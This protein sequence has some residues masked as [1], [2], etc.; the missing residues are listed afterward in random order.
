[1]RFSLCPVCCASSKLVPPQAASTLFGATRRAAV[2]GLPA[3][4]AICYATRQ[5]FRRCAADMMSGCQPHVLPMHCVPS[6]YRPFRCPPALPRAPAS[7]SWPALPRPVSRHRAALGCCPASAAASLRQR[8]RCCRTARL[9]RRSARHAT[10]VACALTSST[11][12]EVRAD[13]AAP[14]RLALLQRTLVNVDWRCGVTKS[15]TDVR[16]GAGRTSLGEHRSHAQASVRHVPRVPLRQCVRARA[17]VRA[18]RG[19]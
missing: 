1:M 2:L 16:R 3:W 19:C 4:R 17:R 11:C 7:I 12:S 18:C 10:P 13:A 14:V 9:Q 6:H 15:H 5:L 8:V